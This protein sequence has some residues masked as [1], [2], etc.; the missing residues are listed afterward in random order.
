MNMRTELKR[1]SEQFEA[2]NQPLTADALVDLAKSQ[3]DYPALHA[4][5]WGVS[6]TALAH[7]ARLARAHRLI[8]SIRVII[9]DAPPTRLLVHTAGS[10]GYRPIDHVVKTFDLAAQKLMELQNDIARSRSRLREF[11][12]LLPDDIAIQI[13]E[14]LSEAERLTQLAPERALQGAA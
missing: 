11:R 8:I 7:E 5:F 9:G 6:E 14:R 10:Q 12:S 2:R 4:H 1:A 13:D 3:A